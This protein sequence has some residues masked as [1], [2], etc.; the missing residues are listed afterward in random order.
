MTPRGG[1]RPGSGR[2][3]TGDVN[4]YVRI[5]QD[6]ADWLD[7]QVVGSAGRSGV[8]RA[9]LRAVMDWTNEETGKIKNPVDKT[10]DLS[11]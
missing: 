1:P 8:V 2:P 5:P 7:H 9:I 10:G 6:I 3:G 4:V 11:L